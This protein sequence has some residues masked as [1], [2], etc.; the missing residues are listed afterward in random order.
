MSKTRVLFLCM[1]NTAR[2]QMAEAFLRAYGGEGFEAHSAGLKP[3]AIQPLTVTVMEELGIDIRGYH[4]KSLKESLGRL[5]FDYLITLCNRAERSCPRFLGVGTRLSWPFTD[6]ATFK[7]TEEE[8]LAQ[9]R[10]LRDDIEHFIREWLGELPGADS[11][12][13][14]R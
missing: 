12:A 6:P 11:P 3:R 4:A 14:T 13:R 1:G 8:R 2:S 5:H 10:K 9:F 7:G